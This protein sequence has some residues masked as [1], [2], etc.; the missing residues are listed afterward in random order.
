MKP[1]IEFIK[2]QRNR[3]YSTHICVFNIFIHGS[4]FVDSRIYQKERSKSMYFGEVQCPPQ[5][6]RNVTNL[7]NSMLFTPFN[8][9]YRGCSETTR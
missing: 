6:F 3:K 1:A 7:S 5:I 9:S 4:V 8:R 2:C